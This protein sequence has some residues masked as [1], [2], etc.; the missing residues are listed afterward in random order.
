MMATR[1]GVRSKRIPRCGFP[2]ALLLLSLVACLVA[3]PSSFAQQTNRAPFPYVRGTAY[4]ILPYT[5]SDE[6]GYFSLCEGR[7][8]KVYVGTAQYNYTSFLVEFDPRTSRQRIV[9]DTRKL[10]GLQ[11]SGYA[12]QAKIHTRNFVG[13]SGKIY[14]GSKQGYKTIPGDQSEYPGGYV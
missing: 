13:P 7:D 6:S 9:I 5:P 1:S 12:A 11:E 8:G 4:H 10:C 14:V 2:G 3:E